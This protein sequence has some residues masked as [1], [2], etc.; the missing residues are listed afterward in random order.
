[1]GCSADEGVQE[2]T[3]SSA[4]PLPA[5]VNHVQ[6][7]HHQVK[8]E[9]QQEE[10]EQQRD[11]H[12]HQVTAKHHHPAVVTTLS[13]TRVASSI[14]SSGVTFD[15]NLLLHRVVVGAGVRVEA[16]TSVS[17]DRNNGVPVA[18]GI[19]TTGK[20]RYFSRR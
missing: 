10:Q 4:H 19:I 20:S 13:S 1:M 9:K 17:D 12:Q 2:R 15:P 7:E 18:N 14:S 6:E 11:E 8:E 16:A 5:V 3:E